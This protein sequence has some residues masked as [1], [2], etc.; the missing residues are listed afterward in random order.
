MSC[1][2]AGK[3]DVRTSAVTAQAVIFIVA[4]NL[5]DFAKSIH[6]YTYSHSFQLT[7]QFGKLKWKLMNIYLLPPSFSHSV[8]EMRQSHQVCVEQEKGNERVFHR[9]QGSN[10][11]T[12]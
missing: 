6:I 2:L 7:K 8:S 4:T 9:V 12:E 5:V 11:A 1:N 10:S 3:D